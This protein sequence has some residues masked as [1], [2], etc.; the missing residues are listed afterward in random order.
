MSVWSLRVRARAFVILS[1][2][3]AVVLLYPASSLAQEDDGAVAVSVDQAKLVRLPQKVTTIVVG[4]P[5]IAD[6]ALQPGNVMVVTGKGYGATNVIAMD[7]AGQ[8]LLDRLIRVAGETDYVI[9]VFS[10]ASRYSYSCTTLCEPR[11]TMGDENRYFGAISGQITSRN[12]QAI[13]MSS[14]RP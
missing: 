5:L 13:G 1:S 12:N 4:N 9:S 7:S 3:S 2:L 10:G 6:V 11:L 14:G 8:V